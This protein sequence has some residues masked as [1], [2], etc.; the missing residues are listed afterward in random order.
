MK[1]TAEKQAE[2]AE[3]QAEIKA[4][5]QAKNWDAYKNTETDCWKAEK[6]T[7]KLRFR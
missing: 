7:K 6:S 4:E 2:K 5:N 1:L 3:K